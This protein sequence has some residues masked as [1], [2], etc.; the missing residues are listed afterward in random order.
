MSLPLDQHCYFSLLPGSR[1][2]L[3]ALSEASGLAYRGSSAVYLLAMTGCLGFLSHIG[4]RRSSGASTGGHYQSGPPLAAVVPS[5]C[6]G[7]GRVPACRVP[8]SGSSTGCSGSS[9]SPAGSEADSFSS[10]S[11]ALFYPDAGLSPTGPLGAGGC[12]GTNAAVSAG[13]AICSIVLVEHEVSGSPD[14]RGLFVHKQGLRPIRTRPDDAAR[15]YVPLLKPIISNSFSCDPSA[16]ASLRGA[17]GIVASGSSFSTSGGGSG[18]VISSVQASG[19]SFQFATSASAPL[20]P[21]RYAL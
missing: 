6:C 12:T 10:S 7:F 9:S 8:S 2:D 13:H 1:A 3:Q 18:S 19:G 17:L 5:G 21:H 11:S 20:P 16:A 4:R 14:G 15:P